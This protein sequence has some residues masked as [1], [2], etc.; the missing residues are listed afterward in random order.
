MKNKFLL[1]SFLCLFSVLF[2]LKTQA[3]HLMGGSLNYTYVG[4]NA[5][6]QTATY[7]VVITM[8]RRCDA[9]SSNFTN[10]VN[11]GAYI[12]N[13]SNNNKVLF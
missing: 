5:G 11:L 9:A 13:A 1:Y 3:T 6:T 8:F 12:E 7:D 4:F 10:T 2:A